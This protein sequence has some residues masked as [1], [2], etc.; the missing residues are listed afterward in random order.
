MTDLAAII[1]A[2]VG[3]LGTLGAAV[4]RQCQLAS[5]GGQLM[6]R[7]LILACWRS[8]Q[9]DPADMVAMCR[10]DPA[11]EAALRESERV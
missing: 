11:L 4:V 10:E 1:T 8:G 5:H 7:A 6:T 3:L 9:I 2:L